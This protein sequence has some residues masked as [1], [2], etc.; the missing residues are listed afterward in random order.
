[1]SSKLYIAYCEENK[2]IALEIEK[3][4][5]PASFSFI[6]LSSSTAITEGLTSLIANTNCPG[7]LLLSDNLLKDQSCM[8]NML[9]FFQSSALAET[10]QVVI[11]DGQYATGNV[12]TSFDR[13]SNVIKYMNY[14]QEKYL[15][16]RKQKRT[17]DASQEQ[18][19]G[20]KLQTV[21]DI[22]SEI[23]DFLRLVRNKPFWTHDQMVFNN[24]E[25]FFKKY[26]ST[27]QHQA[28]SKVNGGPSM[29][30]PVKANQPTTPAPAPT[31]TVTTPTV[32][33]IN[34]KVE[35]I[36]SPPVPEPVA[37]SGLVK[38]AIIASASIPV[39]NE[40]VASVTTA[41]EALTVNDLFKKDTPEKTVTPDVVPEEATISTNQISPTP[42]EINLEKEEEKINEILQEVE[43]FETNE[44]SN[45]IEKTQLPDP[46]SRL[47]IKPT[48]TEVQVSPVNTLTA[49]QNIPE[50]PVI[51]TTNNVAP[52]TIQETPV[53]ENKIPSLPTEQ[54]VIEI[55]TTEEIQS[56]V[57]I[58]D[59]TVETEV[60][61]DEIIDEIIQ[62][63]KVE[64]VVEEV[65]ED[66]TSIE[67][68]AEEEEIEEVVFSENEMEVTEDVT[69]EEN[70]INLSAAIG[71]ASAFMLNG[72]HQKGQSAF[73][74]IL[75]DHPDN[76]EARFQYAHCLR[77][78]VND[79]EM[80]TAQFE[81]IIKMV[82]DHFPSYKALAEISEQNND[83]LLAKSYYEKVS[84]LN[85]SEPGVYYKLGLICAGFF[86]EKPKVACKYF[87]KAIL[88]D[89]T[90][91][92]A[93][94]RLGLFQSE[95][96]D[97]K[98]KAK[99]NFERTLEINPEHKF[100]NYDLAML[101]NRMDQQETAAKHYEMAWQINPELKTPENDITFQMDE[102]E[103]I[104]PQ[105][106]TKD[107][108]TTPLNNDKVI[109]ITGGTSGIG[110]ATAKLFVE[111]GFKVIITGRRGDRL[112]EM[113]QEFKKDFE[114]DIKTLQFDVRNLDEVKSMVNNLE[115]DWRNID[116]LINNAGL[117]KGF[118][119]IHEGNI[120]HWET[121]IDTN[122]K[123]LLY[124]TR[125]VAPHMVERKTGHIINVC[126]TAGKEVYNKGNV[127]CATK[128]AVDALTKA[129]RL[130][131][132]KYNIRVGQV[133]P[134]HVEETEF[135]YV[136][137][138][139]K[140]K[141]KIYDDFQP[142]KSSDV[143][144]AIFYIVNTP[145]H[146]NVQDIVL[147]GKQQAN[148]SNIDRSGREK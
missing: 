137:F 128:H 106:L 59:T 26:G 74:Q 89:P 78:E 35:E 146:V 20:I 136:R 118:D 77:E 12:E 28:F 15:E 134:A 80:A 14:W 5:K 4:L 49:E 3:K 45:Q 13:V 62:E 69:E 85:P 65:I 121:M 32:N 64:E 11:T 108:Q 103:D 42:P 124:L 44:I 76:V 10:M 8:R 125:A 144:N 66:P 92:D 88:Q 7:I 97:K 115:P 114:Q 138:E 110:Q 67:E 41:K 105:K 22:S 38:N 53:I 111:H 79:L 109:M 29:P 112:E 147:M 1:M 19:F 107:V 132:Y 91:E 82:P 50:I 16:L 84:N 17:I 27:A 48:E 83:F 117:A 31:P 33:E 122:I 113:K 101:Y 99:Y 135:A 30:S 46:G 43:H 24:Y 54:P 63:Q 140:E 126:S 86:A 21:K 56:T 25:V 143:A 23:G 100:A 6:Q 116:I 87:K 70:V 37:S 68:T 119:P 120:D 61:E 36:K 39:I 51:E 127:Y 95:L 47:E 18:E 58:E 34:R 93:H 2:S 75:A 81:Q 98:Q 133:S 142:L 71:A 139:D 94:Y 102:I 57:A 131:L 73:E 96:L 145:E 104:T 9:G 55:P 60:M 130:D 148:S 72:A 40:T 90:N 52:T 129:M 141:A 123:G